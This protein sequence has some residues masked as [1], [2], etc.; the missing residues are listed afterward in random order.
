MGEILWTSA[1]G[2]LMLATLFV[3]VRPGSPALA[4]IKDVTGALAALIQTA[5]S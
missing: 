5:T 2:A 4:A 3:L 1:I